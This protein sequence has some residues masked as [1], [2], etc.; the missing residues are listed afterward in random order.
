[1]WINICHREMFVPR[2]L[3]LPHLRS[4]WYVH[5][6]YFPITSD[7][8]LGTVN[9]RCGQRTTEIILALVIRLTSVV[10]EN[11]PYRV[12]KMQDKPPTIAK[13]YLDSSCAAF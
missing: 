12:L 6:W 1:M 11:V 10:S 9:A 5:D 3:G 4:Y 13:E 8:S 2:I 7:Y